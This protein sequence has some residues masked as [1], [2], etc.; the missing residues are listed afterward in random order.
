MS[1]PRTI[2]AVQAFPRAVDIVARHFPYYQMA[3]ADVMLGIGTVGDPFH[4]P[5]GMESTQIGI[6]GYLIERHLP[7]RLLDTLEACLNPKYGAERIVVIEYDAVFLKPIP[8]TPDGFCALEAGG[9]PTPEF[10]CERFFHCLWIFDRDTAAT[11]V[12]VGREMISEGEL[13][14][15]SPDCF[16]GL[17]VD[18]FGIKTT[19]LAGNFSKNSLDI[20]R[21]LLA[22]RDAVRAGAWA[23]HGVK[24]EAQLKALI[25]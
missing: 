7:K 8:E 17:L 20:E 11:V 12:V 10:K 22:A 15:G 3:G 14:H 5:K 25:S 16:L 19:H 6:D 13:E 18:R 9:R 21:D 1:K 2:L 23:V 4:W 24:T